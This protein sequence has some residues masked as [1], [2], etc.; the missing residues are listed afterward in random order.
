[1]P[2]HT[3]TFTGTAASHSHTSKLYNLNNSNY[4]MKIEALRLKAG[5]T[6]WVESS[7]S[8]RKTAGSDGGDPCGITSS[9]SITPKGTNSNT[10]SSTAHNNMP[11]YLAVYVWKRTS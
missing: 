8:N 9:T 10:G 6:D 1:M 3:H 2:K 11:P 7:D 5:Y 4:T